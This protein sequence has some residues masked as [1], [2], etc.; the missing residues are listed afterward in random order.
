MRPAGYSQ[1]LG[2]MIAVMVAALTIATI[3]AV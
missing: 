2:I 3:A 1:T